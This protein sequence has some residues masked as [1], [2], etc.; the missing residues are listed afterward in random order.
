MIF[1]FC[2]EKAGALHPSRPFVPESCGT[3]MRLS[4]YGMKLLARHVLLGITFAK[5]S[6]F[7]GFHFNITFTSGQDTSMERVV[8]ATRVIEGRHMERNIVRILRGP[9]LLRMCY[10]TNPFLPC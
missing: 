9:R 3:R 10:H 7:M 5:V 6:L 1:A 2:P 4:S 8:S